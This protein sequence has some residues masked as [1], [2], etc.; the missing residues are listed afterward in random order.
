MWLYE[1]YDT[2]IIFDKTDFVFFIFK[3]KS[4]FNFFA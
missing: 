4:F 3:Y 2:R 1:F